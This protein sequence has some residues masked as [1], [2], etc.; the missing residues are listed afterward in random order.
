MNRQ[1]IRADV[2]IYPQKS[3]EGRNWHKLH[4][5]GSQVVVILVGKKEIDGFCVELYIMEEKEVN[6]SITADRGDWKMVAQIPN[7]R[8]GQDVDVQRYLVNVNCIMEM[9][10]L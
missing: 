5:T 4:V 2:E 10:I 3:G 1:V 8:Q 7:V 9:G 6:N